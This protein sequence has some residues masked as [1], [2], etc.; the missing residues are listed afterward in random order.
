[1]VGS[2]SPLDGSPSSAV[3]ETTVVPSGSIPVNVAY[4][5]EFT[6]YVIL[7][8]SITCSVGIHTSDS[9]ILLLSMV[10]VVVS[11]EILYAGEVEL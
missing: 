5:I 1:M 9:K 3:L 2:S 4:W 11:T 7:G 8:N 10:V 6:I